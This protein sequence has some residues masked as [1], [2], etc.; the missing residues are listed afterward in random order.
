[1]R[2]ATFIF[3]SIAFVITGWLLIDKYALKG[4]NKFKNKQSAINYLYLV[5]GLDPSVLNGMADDYVIARANAVQQGTMSFI[6][7]GKSYNTATG[8]AD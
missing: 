1:M 6:Y 8:Y 2:T 5:K 7:S 3:S 4:D